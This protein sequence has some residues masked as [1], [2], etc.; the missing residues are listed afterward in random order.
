MNRTRESCTKP[1]SDFDLSDH[2]ILNRYLLLG[3][4]VETPDHFFD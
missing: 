2:S 3:V 4:F 1:Y